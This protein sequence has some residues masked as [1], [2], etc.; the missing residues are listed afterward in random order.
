MYHVSAPGMEP[1]DSRARPH[2]KG[3]C[4]GYWAADPVS[5]CGPDFIGHGFLLVHSRVPS[6]LVLQ[7]DGVNTCIPRSWEQAWPLSQPEPHHARIGDTG[8]FEV[9]TR[10]L[11][12]YLQGRR[13][14]K[15]SK[16]TW[17]YHFVAWQFHLRIKKEERFT[18]C[19][20]CLYPNTLVDCSRPQVFLIRP[21]G[22]EACE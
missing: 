11:V 9:G 7:K 21:P 15:E 2:R 1:S 22:R 18:L 8:P 19:Q 13:K 20:A 10:K 16:Q 6:S 12:I 3:R 4:F 5:R 14:K 17:L